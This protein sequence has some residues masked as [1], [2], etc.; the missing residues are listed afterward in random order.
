MDLNRFDYFLAVVK[1]MSF[2]RA[3]QSLH[4]SRQA[5]S[6][7]IQKLE[8]QYGVV[9]FERKPNLK[10][11]LAGEHMVFY[12]TR[13]IEDEKLMIVEFSDIIANKKT[14]LIVGFTRSVSN[15]FMPSIWEHYHQIQPH[16]VI[17][18]VEDMTAKLEALL[19]ENEIALYIGVNTPPQLN[20]RC[21]T[22][23]KEI[24]YCVFSHALLQTYMPDNWQEF[25]LSCRDGVDLLQMKK[26]P[27]IM[28]PKGNRLRT[29]VDQIFEMAH[30]NPKIVFETSNH[31]LIYQLSQK[32]SG[33]GL[34]SGMYLSH[35]LK[36][37]ITCK[38]CYI[39]PVQNVL[40]S[41]TFELK[42]KT[43]SAQPRFVKDFI[44]IVKTVFCEPDDLS[45]LM[46]NNINA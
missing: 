43:N 26:L 15:M 37:R 23:G 10:L 22:L 12:A 33:V 25:L 30:I 16:V 40:P 8:E 31:D 6:I 29:A 19:Q 24:M 28:L 1:E 17:V 3:A 2:T 27:F 4:I 13:I 35:A 41:Y 34:F 39:F 18:L 5:L 36:Q 46:K 9:L 14:K 11:T 21:I 38:N 44:D 7:H 32:N 42:I 20:T 45:L